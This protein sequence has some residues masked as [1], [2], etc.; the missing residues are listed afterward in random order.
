[1]G[2]AIAAAANRAPD[3]RFA[4]APRETGEGVAVKSMAK[5]R[6]RGAGDGEDVRR[7]LD[8]MLH[9]S[10]G[11]WGVGCVGGRGVGIE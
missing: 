3:A 4:A 11:V 5:A 8:V 9:L 2:A 6:L 7:E 10:G 1:M